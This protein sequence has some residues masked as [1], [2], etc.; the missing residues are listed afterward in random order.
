MLLQRERRRRLVQKE[1]WAIEDLKTG[2]MRAID[3]N[4]KFT[5]TL[6]LLL[7]LRSH[8]LLL[9]S[10]EVEKVVVGVMKLVLRRGAWS[11]E[12]ATLQS[13]FFQDV[14]SNHRQQQLTLM[15]FS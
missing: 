13:E 8:E 7:L 6:V 11:T 14:D 9:L 5:I 10:R 2:N 15:I 12:D 3:Q 1:R 4:W